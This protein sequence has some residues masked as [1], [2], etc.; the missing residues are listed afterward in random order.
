MLAEEGDPS[1]LANTLDNN[2]GFAVP[3]SAGVYVVHNEGVTPILTTTPPQAASAGLELLAEE[4][5]PT[6]LATALAQ[7]VTNN[8]NIKAAGAFGE[9]TI[10]PGENF[11]FT[12]E[13]PVAGDYLSL[14]TMMVQSNDIIYAT[15]EAGIPLFLA[16]GN[17]YS[18]TVENNLIVAY[19]VGTEVNEYPGAGLNQPIRSDVGAGEDQVDGVVTRINAN[20][21]P[22]ADGF[23]YFPVQLRMRVTITPNP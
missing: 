7:D 4:G 1:A 15:P 22:E 14:A 16:N 21:Q 9:G 13:N 19:D 6:T 11:S 18:G 17:P 3:L 20:N 5:D 8:E 10:G 23:S 2:D 12:I